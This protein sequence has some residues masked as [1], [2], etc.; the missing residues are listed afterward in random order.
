MTV[1]MVIGFIA[2]VLFEMNQLMGLG[3]T[4]FTAAVITASVCWVLWWQAPQMRLYLWLPILL[5][6]AGAVLAWT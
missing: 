3:L 2:R 1:T 4:L 6:F 5:L